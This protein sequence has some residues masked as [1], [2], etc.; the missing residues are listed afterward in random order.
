MKLNEGKLE[1]IKIIKNI[2]K[3]TYKILLIG[4]H[5]KYEVHKRI[6]NGIK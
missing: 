4:L 1:L 3:K 2:S 6:I 5:K